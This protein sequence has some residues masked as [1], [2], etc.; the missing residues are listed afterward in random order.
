MSTQPQG[1]FTLTAEQLQADAA[2][3]QNYAGDQRDNSI[4]VRTFNQTIQEAK[5]Q[6]VPQML[7]DK[8]WFEGEL[9]ILFSDS[10]AGKSILATQIAN[11]ICSG[12]SMQPLA[13]EG[14]KQP[15]L[16]CDFELTAKQ[17]EARYSQDW[18]AHY[19]FADNL[20]RADLNPDAELPEGFDYEEYIHQGI[21][22]AIIDTGARVIIID[23]ITYIA[24]ENEQAKFALPLMKQLKA[25][26]T[27]YK[28]SIL[29]LAHTPKRDKSKPITSNDLQGSRM[30]M[31]FCDSSFAI[32]TSNEHPDR[33][34]LK[35]IK[36]RNTAQVYGEANVCVFN[37]IKP[38]NFLQYTFV[39]Y[40]DERAHLKDAKEKEKDEFTERAIELKQQGLSL[41]EIAAEMGITHTR[42]NRMLKAASAGD[43]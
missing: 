25:L 38:H 41:R 15:V 12:T 1:S 4:R 14:N 35:Q 43:R 10:N 8:F 3:W 9:C 19:Q 6:P 11:C 23:N 2:Y 34:Y 39:G 26:K 37:I 20:F 29:A 22:T 32:G 5:E 36:Q 27:Q 21:E 31:N 24:S 17:V 7:F 28:L 42:V 30:L 33:R 18:D 40:G 13:M 16:Y